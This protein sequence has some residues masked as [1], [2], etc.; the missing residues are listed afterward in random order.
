MRIVEHFYGVDLDW[1]E[2]FAEQLEGSVKGNFI[3]AGENICSGFRYFLDCGEDVTALYVNVEYNADI[4]FIHKSC[5]KDFIIFYYNLTDI[6]AKK[7]STNFIYDVGRLG[8]DLSIIDSSLETNYYVKSGSKTIALCIFIKK[9]RVI[10]F[11][12]ENAEFFENMSKIMDSEK[13]TFIKFDK[14]SYKS[15]IILSELQKIPVGGSVFDLNLVSSVHLLVSD[16]LR[17]ML[18]HVIIL[19]KVDTLDLSSIVKVQIFLIENITGAFPSIKFLAE[20]ANMSVSKFKLLFGKI[21]GTT[22]SCFFMAYKLNKAKEL[23]QMDG[24]TISEV[25]D[26]LNFCNNA[27]F[28][29]KFKKNFGISPLT[30]IKRL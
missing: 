11:A 23:L 4:H 3:I 2:S 5:K 13:N 15:N 25:T 12:K 19:E 8:Y 20:R 29:N 26:H 14:M 21:T 27:Y 1:V 17:Q 30:F 10:S 22:P 16:Y 28:I 6:E 9:T 24:Y 18:G 7:T